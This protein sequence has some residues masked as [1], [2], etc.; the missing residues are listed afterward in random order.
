MG[1]VVEESVVLTVF[2]AKVGADAKDLEYS[3]G[4]GII[5]NC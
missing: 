2:N 4:A 1:R 3:G 5:W